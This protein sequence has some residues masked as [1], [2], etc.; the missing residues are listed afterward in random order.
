M[1]F[2]IPSALFVNISL[3]TVSVVYLPYI[4]F[5]KLRNILLLNENFNTNL[6]L[7]SLSLDIADVTGSCDAAEVQ[8]RM[9]VRQGIYDSG[10]AQARPQ[11]RNLYTVHIE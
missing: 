8:A 10:K 11:H 5:G 6:V 1:F 2:F 7:V 4:S 3:D 9:P